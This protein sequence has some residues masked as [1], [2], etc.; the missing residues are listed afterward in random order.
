[1]QEIAEGRGIGNVTVQRKTL[2]GS[3]YEVYDVTLAFVF[4]AF[5]EGGKIHK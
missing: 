1:L 4:H 3:R 2:Q 5:V